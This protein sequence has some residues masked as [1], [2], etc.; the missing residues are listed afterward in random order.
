MFD[1][2]VYGILM[3]GC[4]LGSFTVVI[5]GFDNGNLGV[6]CNNRYSSACDEVFRARATAYATMTWIFLLF[7]WELIDFRRSLFYMPKG[8][9]AWANHLWGNKFLFF[10]VTIVFAIVFPT[11][12]I[13]GLNHVV[14]L[15]TGITWEWAVVFISVGVWMTGTESWK[16]AKRVYF[17]RT[18]LTSQHAPGIS[19][20]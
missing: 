16:W 5:F 3:A 14:F 9:G 1:M 12:Y 8:I 19:V 4:V 11:I 20:V 6:D 15:H 18:A 13:P 2:V 17:R 10:S 7:S